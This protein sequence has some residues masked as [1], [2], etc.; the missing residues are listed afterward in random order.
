M[1]GDA[2]KQIYGKIRKVKVSPVRVKE[3]IGF[4]KEEKI[5]WTTGCDSAENEYVGHKR[6]GRLVNLVFKVGLFY[7]TFI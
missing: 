5:E 3:L 7:I 2:L 6:L 1:A 4:K